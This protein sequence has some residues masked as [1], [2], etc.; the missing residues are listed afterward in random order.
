MR[1]EVF[2]AVKMSMAIFRDMIQCLL[3]DREGGLEK[4]V[5]LSALEKT[6]DEGNKVFFVMLVF[7]HK[8]ISHYFAEEYNLKIFERV[9]F[10]CKYHVYRTTKADKRNGNDLNCT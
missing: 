6:D 1:F 8:T 7:L 10:M 5:P 3:I 4:L 2:N 9:C